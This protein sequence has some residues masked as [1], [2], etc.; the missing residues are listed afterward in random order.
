MFCVQGDAVTSIEGDVPFNDMAVVPGTGL[1]FFAAE[2]K[3][4]KAYFIPVSYYI[5]Y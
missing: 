2:D 3:A 5:L 1:A 4:M